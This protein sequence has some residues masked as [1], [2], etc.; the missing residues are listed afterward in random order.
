MSTTVETIFRQFE[1]SSGQRS[2][3]SAGDRGRHRTKVRDTIKENIADILSDESIIGKSGDKIIKVPIKGIKEYRFVYG[4]NGK[5][6]GTGDGNVQQGQTVGKKGDKPGKGDKAGDQAGEDIYETDVTLDELTE[7]MFEDLNLPNLKKKSQRVIENL[8]RRKKDGYRLKGIHVRLDRRKT[9]INR[10]KRKLIVSKHDDMV[11]D[12]N[13]CAGTGVVPNEQDVLCDT[14]EG[15]GVVNKRFR[16]HSNDQRYKHL[17]DKPKPESNALII[18]MMDTSGSM[19]N[20]KKYLARA[21][22]LTFYMFIKSK[23]KRAEV[24]FIAHHTEAKEVTEDEFFH[25]G[26]SGGTFISSAYEKA[27]QVIADR[28]NS[29]IWNI[30]AFHCSDGDNFDS[31][32]P[33]AIEGAIKLCEQCNEFGYIEIKPQGSRYYESSMLPKFKNDV[34][35]KNFVPMLVENKEG[36]F[37]AIKQALSVDFEAEKL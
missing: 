9:A 5:G 26:E 29:S 31:D 25:K 14:C 22:C 10:V 16:F 33:K 23:Y 36:V 8:A 18:Y 37:P 1:P 35:N 7:I 27:L 24:V 6:V 30:Y 11:E 13:D 15:L 2:D 20:T 4:D 19:D 21:F 12:C 3:R 32:N 28:Y 34:K 17:D